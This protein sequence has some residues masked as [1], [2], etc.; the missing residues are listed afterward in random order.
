METELIV[1]DVP[2]PVFSKV[3]MPVLRVSATT[4]IQTD[5]I[6]SVPGGDDQG[7]VAAEGDVLSVPGDDVITPRDHVVKS[8][9][10]RVAEGGGDVL[11][12]PGDVTLSDKDDGDSDTLSSSSSS[13]SLSSVTEPLETTNNN[14]LMRGHVVLAR[15]GDEGW[16]FRG[17]G[18]F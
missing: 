1:D 12:V 2:L 13:S 11:S 7:V 14:S 17:K 9:D 15:W 4:P 10:H 5:D 3:E 16:Y 8:R 6:L 18:T